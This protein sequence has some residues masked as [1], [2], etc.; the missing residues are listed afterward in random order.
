MNPVKRASIKCIRLKGARQNNLKGFDIDVP[1]GKFIV[2]T[3]LSGS[4]K[5]SLVFETLHAEGQR[6]YV[7]TFSPYA[8]QF[9]EMMDRP[10]VKGIENVRPSI[11]IEQR[12][13]V[14]TSRSTVGTM[15]ELCDFFKVWFCHVSRLY[16]PVSGERIED[17]NPQSIW[18]K[19]ERDWNGRT[20]LLT[21]LIKRPHDTSW[22]Q[23]RNALRSQGYNRILT[24]GRMRTLDRLEPDEFT[25][26][27]ISVIQDRL[28]LDTSAKV[29][30]IDSAQT[31]LRFGQGTMQLHDGSGGLLAS[32]AE[33]LQSPVSG[34]RFHRPS[35]ALFSFNSPVGACPQ[36]RGFGRIIEI[37]DRLVIPDRSLSISQGVIKAFQG[38]IYGQ[39]HLDLV[40]ACQQKGIPLDVPYD[41]LPPEHRKYVIEGDPNYGTEGKRWPHAWYGVR[42]FFKWLEG[43]VYKMHV[44]VFLSKFR[45]YTRCPACQ[46]DRLQPDPLNWKWRGRTLPALYRIPI[47]ELLSLMERYHRATG[48]RQADIAADSIRTRLR[49]L[50]QVGLGYL[51][52]DRTSRTLSGGEAERVSLTSCLGSSLVD[53]LFVLDEPSIGLHSRDIHRLIA[54]LERLARQGNT[55]IVVEHDETIIR[56]A[57]EVIELGPKPGIE[58]G[59]LIYH[60]DIDGLCDREDSI[61]AN[62]LSGRATI[63]LPDRRRSVSRNGASDRKQASL[64]ISGAS[65]HNIRDL[66]VCLPL[67]RFV[68]VSGVSGSGKSTLLNNMIFQGLRSASG[69]AVQDPASMR[70]IESDIEFSE[71][72][73]VDQTALSRTPRSNAALFSGAWNLIRELFATTDRARSSGLTPSSFSFNSGDGRCHLCNGLG[74]E[75]VEMQFMADVFVTCPSCGG[76][77][78]QPEILAVTY[79]DRSIADILRMNTSEAARFFGDHPKIHV[80]LIT[81]LKVGL[82]YL[83]LGQ[84]LNT[85]S[86]GESQR[87]KLVRYLS[88]FDGVSHP[89]LLLLD[90]PTTG[91]HRHDVKRLISVLQ[92]IVDLGHSLIVIEHHLDILK[93]A[94]WVIEMGP[95]AGSDG[96][97][98]ICAGT[99]EDISRQAG[100]TAPFLRETL[101]PLDRSAPEARQFFGNDPNPHRRGENG[102]SPLSAP[103]SGTTRE[104][105]AAEPAAAYRDQKQ[106]SIQLVGARENNLRNLSV[107][108]PLGKISVITG[109]SGS[110]KSTLAFDTIFAEGQRRFME[111]MSPYA[112]QFVEQIPRP[113]IDL[114]TGI[115]PTVAIEQRVT[116]GTRKSTVATITEVAQYLRLLYARI[117][118]Q[119]SRKTGRPLIAQGVPAL[120]DRLL[121]LITAHKGRYSS[122]LYL[123]APLVRGRKGHHQPLADWAADHGYQ[124]LRIDGRFVRI[125]DFQ[126]LDRYRE[127][128]I[129]VVVER[130]LPQQG[131]GPTAYH[132]LLE[133]ALQLGKGTCL[134][135]TTRGRIVAWLSTKKTDPSTGQSYPEL[136]PKHFSW[137]SPKGWC[138]ACRGYGSIDR[139]MQG[140]SEFPEEIKRVEVGSLCPRCRG[141]RLNETSSSVYLHFVDGGYHALP[142]LLKLTP[143]AL[144]GRLGTLKL[145][146]RGKS[147]VKDLLPEIVERLS[148]MKSVGLDYLTMDRATVTLS[149]GEAQR[150]RLAAQLGSNLSGV[151]YVLDEPSIGLHASDNARLLSSLRNLRRK[152]NTL[153]IVEHDEQTM[154]EADCIVDLGPGA[155]LHGGSVLAR[156]TLE[157]IVGNEDSLTGQYLRTG[158]SHPSRG[159]YRTLP[160][161]HPARSSKRNSDWLTLEKASLRNLKGDDL[162]LPR[163]RLIMVCGISGAGKSTLIRDL[164]KPA[165]THASKS[166]HRSLNGRSFTKSGAIVTERRDR[167]VFKR[168]LNGNRF[169][170]V[171]EVDQ[172]PIGKTPRSTPATYTGAFDLIRGLFVTLPEARMLG[173]SPSTYSFNT[174][175]G[176]CEECKGAGRIKLAMNFMPDTYVVC[177]ECGGARYGKELEEIRWK[178]KNIA[179]VLEMSF[180]T[181]SEF[182]S[183]HR[184]LHGILTL[185]VEAGLGYLTL[186][187]SSP[188]LSGGEAQRLKLVSELAKGLQSSADFARGVVPANLYILEEP[189]IGLHLADCEIL[190]EVLHRLVDQGHTVIV[191]EHHIDLIA[192]A[193]YV[194][195]IGPGGGDA[196]GE[197]LYQGTINGLRECPLS[198]TAPYLKGTSNLLDK[199]G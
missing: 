33:G 172:S 85:L 31:A 37:D 86:G 1:L 127:H 150:I 110:G 30:F 55:V 41:R 191:I 3:G 87:L 199:G 151:L 119:H 154:R 45:A 157:A 24:N 180:E 49:Y 12:N 58:G 135:M 71:V 57:D 40:E 98:V 4:G 131:T 48:D 15:T 149:G 23:I 27:T 46:G 21:F 105:I 160:T 132:R 155:G 140:H 189:T 175:T 63:E 17:D 133:R 59:R 39:S 54:I 89:A 81:L 68:A 60:G 118:V 14:K 146:H 88:R 100:P 122:N 97:R 171:I 69:K 116:H 134:L 114:I 169:R 184:R 188:T 143:E 193:D 52:L 147:I 47:G 196:G 94:D 139:W 197:I 177:E 111:S 107:T 174:R 99:P 77:R 185:M 136:D 145:D 194:V 112:R 26:Q 64:R 168:L 138:P 179:E 90:E 66:S 137:N 44:R 95:G 109:V 103:F 121:G 10:D 73:L 76:Q 36:C 142:D 183:F 75:R 96:G 166:D 115:P 70:R 2:V 162:F 125:A 192:E 7:E 84:P 163:G 148:F 195:E 187:Q 120:L 62:Y 173:H 50:D 9:L 42:R 108:F 19:A 170:R 80:R 182:F 144:L 25:S 156:G 126:K 123:C 161:R 20:I 153:L 101:G 128:D 65:K 43:N 16:D 104:L 8:R 181:A 164:L 34:H 5:S 152:G 22:E 35:P 106:T 13:T 78:F 83:P 67:E 178:G 129:E 159:S 11:A 38:S 72:L 92:E 32:Y 176:R 124:I 18:K 61:T 28:R 74:Y 186:G 51:T 82:G 113:D 130:I 29:R 102:G 165:V 158:I 6:R 141:G 79:R 53:T 198:P 91:L 56:A 93:S 190:I 117:G 167:P